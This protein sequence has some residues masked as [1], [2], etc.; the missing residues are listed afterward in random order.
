MDQSLAFFE[1]LKVLIN[2][3]GPGFALEG[4]FHRIC[5]FGRVGGDYAVKYEARA[6]H[7]NHQWRP[8]SWGEESHY[9]LPMGHYPSPDPWLSNVGFSSGIIWNSIFPSSDRPLV[10]LS[11][12]IPWNYWKVGNHSWNRLCTYSRLSPVSGRLAA[13][14]SAGLISS[15][16]S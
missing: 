14:K 2:L 5:G 10:T 3:W 9:P 1:V 12:N 4:L 11:R 6:G 15:Q 13:N 8:I 7:Q 16:S